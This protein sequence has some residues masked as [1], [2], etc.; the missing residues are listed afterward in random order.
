L[1][2]AV[3]ALPPDRLRRIVTCALNGPPDLRSTGL[4]LLCRL[5]DDRLRGRLADYATEADDETLTRMLRATIDDNAVA[6]LL[7]AVAAMSPQAQRRVLAL[8]ALDDPDVRIHL[9]KATAPDN[10]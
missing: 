9:L 3:A 1:T 5:E 7:T 8:P 10:R 4:A 2:R 6:D